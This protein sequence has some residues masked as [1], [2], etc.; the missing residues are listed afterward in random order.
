MQRRPP[1]TGTDLGFPARNLLGEEGVMLCYGAP[2]TPVVAACAPRWCLQSLSERCSV[3]QHQH[4]P[5]VMPLRRPISVQA[6][7]SELVRRWVSHLSV[8]SGEEEGRQGSGSRETFLGREAGKW[9]W[10]G[11][12][13]GRE[14]GKWQWRGTFLGREAGKWCSGEEPSLEGRQGSGSRGTFLG[15][16]AGKGQ[17]P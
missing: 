1:H 17:W 15:R 16:E 3:C 5:A 12:F 7:S 4:H 10:R 6:V 13:R 2:S 11:T 8:S 9:Q 14:A